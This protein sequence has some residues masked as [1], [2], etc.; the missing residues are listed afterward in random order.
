MA[1]TIPVA[2]EAYWLVE[3]DAQQYADEEGLI[4]WMPATQIDP[5][6][7]DRDL[8]IFVDD[9]IYDNDSDTWVSEVRVY[10]GDG[11]PILHRDYT[12]YYVGAYLQR[13]YEDV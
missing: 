12:F 6:C 4:R 10:C 8:D 9:L 1:R 2:Q 7:Y 11:N 5:G 13:D 3:E